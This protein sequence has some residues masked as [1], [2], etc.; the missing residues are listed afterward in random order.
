MTALPRGE[1]VVLLSLWAP[2]APALAQSQ[3]AL[4]A[5]APSAA[6]LHAR[7]RAHMSVEGVRGWDQ[8]KIPSKPGKLRDNHYQTVQKQRLIQPSS[9]ARAPSSGVLLLLLLPRGK[10]DFGQRLNHG[11]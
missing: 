7:L 11:L 1:A 8:A 4:Y 9:S 2:F 5:D 10:R 3:A 6:Y